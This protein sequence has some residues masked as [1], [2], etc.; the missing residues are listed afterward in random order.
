MWHLT[1]K[2]SRNNTKGFFHLC[3]CKF[4]CLLPK[5]YYLSKTTVCKVIIYSVHEIINIYI[6]LQED[7]FN[8]SVWFNEWLFNVFW[9]CDVFFSS[10]IQNY[11]AASKRNHSTYSHAKYR[12][13][14]MVRIRN[15]DAYLLVS[16]HQLKWCVLC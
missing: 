4:L 7:E 14:T 12:D 10:W 9:F 11:P 15:G 2:S 16:H 6:F 5:A 8:F 13:G 1:N 3:Q